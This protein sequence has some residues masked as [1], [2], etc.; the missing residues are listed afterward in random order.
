MAEVL[1]REPHFDHWRA[2]VVGLYMALVGY[3]VLA[4]IPVICTAW[5]ELLGFNETQVG[6]VAGADLGGLAAGPYSRLFSC[7]K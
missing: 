2:L 1:H 5:T 4:G 7:P 6:R 3:A